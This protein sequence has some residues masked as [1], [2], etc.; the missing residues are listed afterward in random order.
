MLCP[1]SIVVNWFIAPTFTTATATSGEP[2]FTNGLST[3]E[4]LQLWIDVQSN[5]TEPSD[6]PPVP[7]EALIALSAMLLVDYEFTIESLF[8]NDASDSGASYEGAT[9]YCSR[10]RARN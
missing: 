2:I 10:K 3:S 5:N 7:L 9:K 6:H 1:G 4:V 8:L